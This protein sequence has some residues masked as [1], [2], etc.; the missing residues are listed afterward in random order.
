MTPIPFL[1]GSPEA[2]EIPFPTPRSSFTALSRS[3]STTPSTS[4]A[5]GDDAEGGGGLGGR[6]VSEGERVSTDFEKS[7]R[8]AAASVRLL[9]SQVSLELS[10]YAGGPSF[11]AST[12]HVFLRAITWPLDEGREEVGG[13]GRRRGGAQAGPE[14]FARLSRVSCRVDCSHKAG[15][16][17]N[18]DSQGAAATGVG[19]SRPD[20][21]GDTVLKPFDL[22]VHL[23]RP[24]ASSAAVVA[25]SSSSEMSAATHGWHAGVYVDQLYARFGAA[26]ARS[27]ERL[28]EVFIPA[29]AAAELAATELARR[30][31]ASARVV[32]GHGR[33]ASHINDLR[34]LERVDCLDYVGEAAL[35]PRPG[36]AVFYGVGVATQE[37]QEADEHGAP[38]DGTVSEDGGGGGG[39]VNCC[40]W[41]YWGLRRV[42]Q[43]VLPRTPLRGNVPLLEGLALDSLEVEL[44]FVD[45]LTGSYKVIFF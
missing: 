18:G 5:A 15:G 7:A 38:L 45:P 44:S 29:L 11:V 39:W 13:E 1:E 36:Q 30:Q 16:R 24:K 28:A 35:K 42:A 9:A 2:I 32:G 25:S 3:S 37:S 43:V 14:V 22:D 21:Q 40:E 31:H 19:D 10:S 26:H 34:V 27:L 8:T 41:H 20:R 33:S 17:G 6:A 4:T 12:S 23:T